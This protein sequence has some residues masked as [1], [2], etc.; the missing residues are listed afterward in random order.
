MLGEKTEGCTYQSLVILA[1]MIFD[2]NR[3]FQELF[4]SV[5]QP[6]GHYNWDLES[7]FGKTVNDPP[8]VAHPLLSV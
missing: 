4:L 7:V 1:A 2:R 5:Q 8:V 3:S 6:R